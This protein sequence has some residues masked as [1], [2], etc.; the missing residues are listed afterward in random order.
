MNFT[1]YQPLA[2]RTEKPLPTVLERLAHATLGLITEVGEIA[3]EVKRIV[4]YGKQLTDIDEKTK[5][6]RAQHIAEEIG[7]VM[8]YLAIAA[9]A[10]KLDL[11]PYDDPVQ[12]L[13]DLRA[14]GLQYVVM[15]LAQ[16][17]GE[18]GTEIGTEI[19]GGDNYDG[20]KLTGAAIHTYYGLKIAATLIDTPLEQIMADNIAKLQLRFPEAY[21]NEAAEAR[22]DKGGADA[23]NS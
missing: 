21:S 12:N 8:W 15:G 5:L 3:T 23:R 19:A 11:G 9:D 16:G 22:A 18:F 7:D 6:T 4:I 13:E 10:L 20:E 17:A 2:L 14:A 1:D